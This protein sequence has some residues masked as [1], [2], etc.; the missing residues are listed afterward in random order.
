MFQELK[1]SSSTTVNT[2]LLPK[3]NVIL[4]AQAYA[5]SLLN[6]PCSETGDLDSV[7]TLLITRNEKQLKLS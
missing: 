4:I 6:F 7:A 5:Q 2:L 1:E 3:E